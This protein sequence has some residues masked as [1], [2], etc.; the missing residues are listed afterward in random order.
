MSEL[1]R[2]FDARDHL[3]GAERYSS[4]QATLDSLEAT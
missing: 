2:P 3:R 1:V 4:L